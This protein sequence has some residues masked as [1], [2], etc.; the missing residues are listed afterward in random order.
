VKPRRYRLGRRQAAADQTRARVLAAA[1]RLLVGRKAPREFSLEAVAERAGVTRLTLY[2]RFGSKAGLLEALYDDLGRRGGIAEGLAVAFQ[3]PDA[4]ACLDA[5]VE[6]F[7]RFWDSDRLAFRRLRSM[8][9]LDPDF[10]G[11]RARD[12]RRR[13]VIRAVCERLAADRGRPFADTE[14]KIA[15]L[16]ML[17]GFEAFDALAGATPDIPALAVQIK[18]LAR[19]ALEAG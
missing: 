12:E 13:M 5:A 4:Q 19:A 6:A 10:K 18:A 8:A 1:R 14:A 15:A 11:V 7:L 9:A 17:T 2:H 16:A 3:Q